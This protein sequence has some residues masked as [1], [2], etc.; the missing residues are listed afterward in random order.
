MGVENL[1][2]EF[3]Q[4]KCLCGKAQ[5]SKPRTVQIG[6]DC[7][8]FTHTPVNFALGRRSCTKLLEPTNFKANDMEVQINRETT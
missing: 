3:K 6:A 8:S 7:Q 5:E 4:W 2:C 1:K